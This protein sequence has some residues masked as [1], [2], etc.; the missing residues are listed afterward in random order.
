MGNEESTKI[1]KSVL[2]RIASAYVAGATKEEACRYAGITELAYDRHR[3]SENDVFGEIMISPV[4][5]AFLL[6]KE[7]HGVTQN[8][9]SRAKQFLQK[10][11]TEITK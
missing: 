9:V 5:K 6:A 4:D 3:E 10:A 7:H 1:T 2:R 8:S 11:P